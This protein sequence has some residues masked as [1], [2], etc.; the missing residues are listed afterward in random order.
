[1]Y[2]DATMMDG[3]EGLTKPQMYTEFADGINTVFYD[4]N[5]VIGLVFGEEEASAGKLV[6]AI[7]EQARM[8]AVSERSA[9]VVDHVV[10]IIFSYS[11]KFIFTVVKDDLQTCFK[12]S[13]IGVVLV[14]KRPNVGV[15][16]I[17]DRDGLHTSEIVQNDDACHV[18]LCKEPA[19]VW[20]RKIKWE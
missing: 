11:L 18:H 9:R 2:C 3:F 5:S 6:E 19:V 17:L 15:E 16:V 10:L 8:H 12:S 14:A 13:P 20:E 4:A 7:R 1:M